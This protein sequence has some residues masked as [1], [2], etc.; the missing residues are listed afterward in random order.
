[1][2]EIQSLSHHDKLSMPG[3]GPLFKGHDRELTQVDILLVEEGFVSEDLL[4]VGGDVGAGGGEGG[5]V[6]STSSSVPAP[7]CSWRGFQ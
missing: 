1:M 4:K 2:S 3:P 5:T 7:L 6:L